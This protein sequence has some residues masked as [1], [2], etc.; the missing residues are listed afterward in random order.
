MFWF[1]LLFSQFHTPLAKC[2]QMFPRKST[3]SVQITGDQ[4]NLLAQA[5]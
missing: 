1:V 5:D 4:G 2:W 3:S